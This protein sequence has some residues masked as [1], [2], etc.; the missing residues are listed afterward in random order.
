MEVWD[1]GVP[2]GVVWV[3]KLSGWCLRGKEAVFGRDAVGGGVWDIGGHC[4][5]LARGEDSGNVE[6]CFILA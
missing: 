1:E 2:G 3:F 5:L 4:F 6:K